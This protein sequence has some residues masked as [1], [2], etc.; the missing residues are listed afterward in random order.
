MWSDL[1]FLTLVFVG[2]ESEVWKIE[3]GTALAWRGRG[4]TS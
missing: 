2:S 4:S 3:V 1:C